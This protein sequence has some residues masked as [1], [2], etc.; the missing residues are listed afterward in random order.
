MGR[1]DTA[2]LRVETFKCPRCS[3]RGW[4]APAKS[5]SFPEFCVCERGRGT[6]AQMLG[7]PWSLLDRI[8]REPETAPVYGEKAKARSLAALRVLHL[9]ERKFPEALEEQGVKRAVSG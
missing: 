8:A 5:D 3:G 6:L 9:I 7:V 2:W 4:I 1:R